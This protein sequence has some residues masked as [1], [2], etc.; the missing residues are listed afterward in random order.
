MTPLEQTTPE[1]LQAFATSLAIGLLIGLERERKADA[2]AGLRTYALVAM[3]GA[4]SALLATRSGSGWIVAIGI[5]AV[6]AMMIAAVNIDPHDDGDPGTTS[7]VAA[8][9]CFGLGATVWYGHA[10]LAVMLA[11]ATT[12]LLYFKAQLHGIS[13]SLTHRDLISILQFAVLSF[14]VLPIL[15]DRNY[16]P[17]AA[18]NPHQVWWM[19]VLISG[20][21]LAGYAALRIAGSRHGAALIGIFGG[22]ASSTA[23]TMVFARHARERVDLVRTATLVILLANLVVM[24]RLWLVS[25]AVAPALML[26]LGIVFGAGIAGGLAV[27]LYGWRRLGAQ[28]DLPMPEVKNPTEIRTALSFALLY[29]VVLFLSAWLQDV[30]GNRGLYLVALASGLTDVDAI[31]LSSLRLF[32][33]E[34]LAAQQTVIVIALA[35]LSNLVFKSGLVIVIGGM[36]LAR[37][38]LPGMVAIAA[39]IGT[40]LLVFS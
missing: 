34:K 8:M 10:E 23:T 39:G 20:V 11:I 29:A 14:V 7:V 25:A 40:G 31:T 1:Q 26:S 19:V 4:L 21:S 16:G 27:T 37:H 17:Y 9:V 28:A 13:A 22:F 15:P 3:L 24:V 5:L 36:A 35:V 12:V 6:G 32:N 33:L 18:I 2:K 38:V 30:A